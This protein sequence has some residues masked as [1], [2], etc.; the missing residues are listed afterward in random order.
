MASRKCYRVVVNNATGRSLVTTC[1]VPPQ[2]TIL[3]QTAWIVAESPWKLVDM[4]LQGSTSKTESSYRYPF[5]DLCR[6]FTQS[7]LVNVS[8]DNSDQTQ[9]D[10]I[11]NIYNNK[12]EKED[13]KTIYSIFVTNCLSVSEEKDMSTRKFG[14]FTTLSLVNH[15]CSPNCETI[16][17]NNHN[18]SIQL[19]TVRRIRKGE[20]ITFPYMGDIT[21]QTESIPSDTKQKQ[22]AQGEVIHIPFSSLQ[23]HQ[24]QQLL[25]ENFG[26]NCQCNACQV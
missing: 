25:Y 2:T 1:E 23:K 12:W 16:T 8:W 3:T 18:A 24:R 26:F 6:K 5:K 7:D 21:V 17:T 11:H 15:S 10:T 4:Y 9:L 20:E 13:I 19:K 14:L 22:H